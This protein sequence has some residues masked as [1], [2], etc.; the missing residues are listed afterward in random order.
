MVVCMEVAET[1][2]VAVT[3]VAMMG[4]VADTVVTRTK[5][6]DLVAEVA[7]AVAAAV[8]AEGAECENITV[9]LET[10]STCEDYRI[11]LQKKISSRYHLSR[12]K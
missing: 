4:R 7:W 11:Q 9:Q 2:E 8:I 6:V 5:V 10:T 12:I 3:T 1:T